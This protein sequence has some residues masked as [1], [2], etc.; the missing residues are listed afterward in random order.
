MRKYARPLRQFLF[1]AAWRRFFFFFPFIAIC[2]IVA[3][4]VYGMR[5]IAPSGECLIGHD[6]DWNTTSYWHSTWG[7]SATG[8]QLTINSQQPADSPYLVADRPAIDW[9]VHGQH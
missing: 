6:A 7:D 9:A 3:F 2:L 4:I 5:L 1:S 8:E